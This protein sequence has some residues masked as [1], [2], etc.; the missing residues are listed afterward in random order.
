MAEKSGTERKERLNVLS[1]PIDVLEDEAFEER[2]ESLLSSDSV[3]QIV[4]LGLWD[5]VRARGRSVFARTVRSASLVVPAS[6]TLQH[7]VWFLHGRRLPRYL[8]F[9][10]VVKLLTTLEKKERS[11]YII[12]SRPETLQRAT[13]NVRGSFPGLHVVGR[14]SGEFDRAD[15]ENVILAIRKASPSLILAGNG[16]AG[17][18][19]WL[20]IHREKFVRGVTLWYGPC[21]EMFAGKRKRTSRELWRRGL[22]FLPE[23]LTRPWRIYRLFPYAWILLVALGMR[24][25]D[26]IRGVRP[27]KRTKGRRGKGRRGA[28][29]DGADRRS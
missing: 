9:D 11:V 27:P 8:P 18:D 20:Y 19:K 14:C 26:P 24:L 16:L 13:S 4:L 10:F 15:E 12:G 22:D 29:R 6:K 5:Y 17:R 25:R 23:F 21:I 1:V 7:I 2:I 3:E 28:H